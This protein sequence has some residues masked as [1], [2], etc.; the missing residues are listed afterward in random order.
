MIQGQVLGCPALPNLRG[1]AP[2]G[3]A[4]LRAHSPA[5]VRHPPV[6]S[7]STG[8][9]TEP[10]RIASRDLQAEVLPEPLFTT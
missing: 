10:S 2:R 7:G 1:D 5:R 3:N 4:T 9:S 8:R 6:W